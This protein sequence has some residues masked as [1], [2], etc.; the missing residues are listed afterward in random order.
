MKCKFKTRKQIMALLQKEVE[1]GIQ[2]CPENLF[3][4]DSY[5]YLCYNHHIE[6]FSFSRY[7]E[8]AISQLNDLKS[9]EYPMIRLYSGFY[10]N[11]YCNNL[12]YVFYTKAYY[13][14]CKLFRHRTYNDKRTYKCTE[15]LGRFYK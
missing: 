14:I 12:L 11:D 3:Y 13:L 7:K 6:E 5:L 9:T 8:K 1:K 2:K 4:I 10:G 15:F